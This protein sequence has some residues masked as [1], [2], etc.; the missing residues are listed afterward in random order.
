MRKKTFFLLRISK[1]AFD[2]RIAGIFDIAE[3][4]PTPATLDKINMK[5]MRQSVNQGTADRFNL[6]HFQSIVK[7]LSFH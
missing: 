7:T 4:L 2:E 3:S 1:Y 6:R 5:S